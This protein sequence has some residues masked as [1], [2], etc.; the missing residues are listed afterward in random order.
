MSWRRDAALAATSARQTMSARGE[1]VGRAL[2]FGVLLL[3]FSRL[4]LVMAEEGRLGGVAA[5]NFLWYLAL[6]EWVVLATPM[7]YLT[8]EEDVKRGDLAYSLARPVSYL[9]AK[10]AEGLG[11]L[12]VRCVSLGVLG[13]G[14]AWLFIGRLPDQPLAL[15]WALPTGA[16]A[17]VLLMQIQIAIGLCAFWI[18]EAAPVYWIVQK[19]NFVFGGLLFPLTFYPDWLRAISEATPFA[20][21]V[22]GCGKLSFGTTTSAAL[23]TL[24]W[25]VVWN[26]VNAGFVSVVYGRG[27]RAVEVHG[28]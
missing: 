13:F 8:I 21:A 12:A 24:L 5:A 18:H 25:L 1:L 4:W 28:G 9:R 11:E 27:V 7:I 6:T 20:A 26:V 14:L 3:V 15:L 16:L 17:M 10:F 23:T 19:L 22:Y 2:F